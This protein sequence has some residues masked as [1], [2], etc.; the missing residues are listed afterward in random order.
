MQQLKANRDW[1]A[2]TIGAE[3]PGVTLRTP[4]ATYLAWL[5]CTALGLPTPNLSTGEHNPNSPLE[6]TCVEEMQRAVDVLVAL[7]ELWGQETTGRITE[8]PDFVV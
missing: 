7:A 2:Q 1:L 4:E 5:D 3:L 8:A 6:W